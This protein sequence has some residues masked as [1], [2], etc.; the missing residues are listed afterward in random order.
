MIALCALW[1]IVFIHV[2]TAVT[3]PE[4]LNLERFAIAYT[5]GTDLRVFPVFGIQATTGAHTRSAPTL[6]CK[7]L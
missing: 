3:L 7:S 6:I 1:L 5:V 2:K 4:S